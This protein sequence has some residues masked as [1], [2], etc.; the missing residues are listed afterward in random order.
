MS[1]IPEWIT[2]GFIEQS[3]FQ[4]SEL[5]FGYSENSGILADEYKIL[6]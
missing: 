5:Q 1:F 2:I 6:S 4:G 3:E